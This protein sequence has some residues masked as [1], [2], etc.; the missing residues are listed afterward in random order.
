[1]SRPWELLQ[2][3]HIL[4]GVAQVLLLTFTSTAL[5]MPLPQRFGGSVA[6]A[7]E[8]EKPTVGIVPFARKGEVG[9]LAA[10]RIEEYMRQTI[11]AAEALKLLPAKVI[12]SGKPATPI[13]K[14]V[15]EKPL[16]PALKALD[17]ADTLAVTARTMVEEGEDPN[18]TLKLLKAAAQ[19]YEDNFVELIDFTKL[20]DVYAQA[21]TVSLKL[22][23]T[24]AA[25]EWLEK[26]VVLQP[27][28][29][30]DTRKASKPLQKAL[31]E[32][33]QGLADKEGANLTIDCPAAG[34]DVFVDGVKV[35][36]CPSQVKDLLQGTHYVQVR[37]VGALPWGQTFIAKGKDG[38]ITAN[39]KVEEDASSIGL[40]IP[41]E[42][43]K[44]FAGSGNFHEKVFKNMAA[45]FSKQIGA[46][47][48]LYGVVSKNARNLELHLFLF[49]AKTKRTCALDK[50]EYQPTLGDLQMKTLD[51]EGRVRAALNTCK[52]VT[53]LPAIF[54]AGK[55][56]REEATA[57]VV[58]V[59]P[60]PPVLEEEEVAPPPPPVKTKATPKLEPK[61]EPKPEPKIRPVPK[62]EP[63]IDADAD[64]YAGLLHDE[65]ETQ[66]KP[67]YKKWWPW[68]IAGVLVAGGVVTAVVLSSQK[69]APATGFAAVGIVP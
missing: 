12:E 29:V 43:V 11:Q 65:D 8:A 33:R 30:V 53:D 34:A 49:H 28:F 64:P 55:E 38:S 32:A 26:A 47:Y 50:V 68:T 57:A 61:P 62:T 2:K 60:P 58:P 46:Q 10:A 24:K 56:E 19:R 63:T 1:V 45:A 16:S 40:T 13:V 48:L 35:G 66:A 18:D 21:A 67:W 17:R 36:N 31:T 4:R 20:I 5:L 6:W 51:A 25:K 69:A 15:K 54:D 41:P 39:I 37:K 44:A 14:E 27:T 23:D 7:Q 22:N 3:D 52:E 42:D 59:P 9:V